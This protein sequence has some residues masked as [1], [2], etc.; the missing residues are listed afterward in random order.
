MYETLENEPP[1]AYTPPK[2]YKGLKKNLTVF[3]S[4]SLE[5]GGRGGY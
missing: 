2:T 5:G 1:N 4:W 3:V